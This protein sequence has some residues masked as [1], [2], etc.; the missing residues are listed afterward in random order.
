MILALIFRQRTSNDVLIPAGKNDLEVDQSFFGFGI[1]IF[2]SYSGSLGKK[3][4]IFKA[5]VKD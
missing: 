4:A 5:I 1:W 2:E 3:F